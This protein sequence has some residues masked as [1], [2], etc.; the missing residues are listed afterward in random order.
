MEKTYPLLQSQLGVFMECMKNPISTQY[1]FPVS[2][3]LPKTIDLDRLEKALQKI[4]Q[5]SCQDKGDQARRQ[6]HNRLPCPH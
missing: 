6:D 5:L 4:I 1:N 2:S 3:V